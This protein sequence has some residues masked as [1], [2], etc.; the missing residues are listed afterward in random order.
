[1]HSN[2]FIYLFYL[3][4]AIA[5][6]T[7]ALQFAEDARCQVILLRTE[8]QNGLPL[9]LM[10]ILSL[11]WPPMLSSL[12]TPLTSWKTQAHW[13]AEPPL[14]WGVHKLTVWLLVWFHLPNINVLFSGVTVSCLVET[15]CTVSTNTESFFLEQIA[16]WGHDFCPCHRHRIQP[17]EPYRSVTSAL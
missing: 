3:Y 9:A 7:V 4:M 6:C 14:R 16:L 8:G 13:A 1:M 2:V 5:F 17:W 15:G 12:P 10:L 11:A